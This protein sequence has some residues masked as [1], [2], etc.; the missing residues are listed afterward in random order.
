MVGAPSQ[1]AEEYPGP[2]DPGLQPER[3]ALAWQRTG[4]ALMGLALLVARS[5]PRSDLLLLT[6]IALAVGSS[7]L[8]LVFRAGARFS[9]ADR[10]L[11]AWH[12]G[13]R[14]AVADLRALDGR[15]PLVAALGATLLAVL[16]G[17]LFWG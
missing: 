10:N 4:L 8:I 7:G 15:L 17:A 11:R 14:Y 12:R 2:A 6:L 5:Q 13:E 3:T 9:A 16:V 1:Q